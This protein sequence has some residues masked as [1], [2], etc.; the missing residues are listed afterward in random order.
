MAHSNTD[1]TLDS[2]ARDWQTPFLEKLAGCGNVSRACKAAKI[3]RSTAYR[4][5][6]QDPDF[7]KAWDESLIIAVGLLEDEA[8]R[9]AR[10]GWMEPVFQKGAQVGQVRKFSDQLLMFLLRAHDPDKYRE[11][12]N[13]H[14]SG[15]IDVRRA[16]ELSDDELAAIASR[17]SDGTAEA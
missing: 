5:R 13:Q 12:V 14:H 16:E 9:R 4:L 1:A 8:W 10:E 2:S 15:S 11:T 7:K 6:A 17:S 3:E